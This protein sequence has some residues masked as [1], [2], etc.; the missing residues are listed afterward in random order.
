[1]DKNDDGL[2]SKEELIERVVEVGREKGL[3]GDK[4]PEKPQEE[5]VEEQKTSPRS[6]KSEKPSAET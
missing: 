6:K 3:F 5:V 1:M 2:I 4:S